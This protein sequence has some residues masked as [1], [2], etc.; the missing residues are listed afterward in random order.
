[1][2]RS[3]RLVIVGTME[4]LAAIWEQ[5]KH[6]S[7][8]ANLSWM[9]THCLLISMLTSV[10]TEPIPF[11]RMQLIYTITITATLTRQA[12]DSIDL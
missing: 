9:E 11:I 5:S 8:H 6:P 7:H 12:F 2:F 1:M 4:G 3:H 10:G